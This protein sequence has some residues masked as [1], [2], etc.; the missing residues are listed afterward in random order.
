[1]SKFIKPNVLLVSIDA[2]GFDLA[3]NPE[4][5]G[6]RLPN[7][8][9]FLTEGAYSECG[10][11]PIF[12]SLTYCCHQSIITGTHP[13]THGTYA[14]KYFDPT[15]IYADAWYWYASSDVPTLWSMAKQ[16]GY[17]SV[18]VGFPTGVLADMD[19]NIP[20]I[21][22]DTTQLD[23]KLLSAV[24]LPQE[25]AREAEEQVGRIRCGLWD[26][27]DDATKLETCLWMLDEKIKPRLEQQPFFMTTYFAAYDD[28]AHHV[29]TFGRKALQYLEKT[30]EY[31][32]ILVE[33]AME[34]SGGNLVI[35]VIS[36]HGMTDNVCD[37]R[38]NTVFFQNDYLSIDEK[39]K[40]SDWKV[41]AQRGGGAANIQLKDKSDHG[42]REGVYQLLKDLKQKYP[43]LIDE[44][45]TGEQAKEQR[46]GYAEA[47]FVLTTKIGV[48]VRE[49]WDGDFLQKIPSQKAQ[50][51]YHEHLK[52]MRSMFL[53]QGPGIAKGR[54]LGN[55]SIVDIAPSL[56][57]IM[58]FEM[59]TS[60]G[61]NV[62]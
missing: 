37:I 20:E 23:S 34:L 31:L 40:I 45:M 3:L 15:G 51:G 52:D 18:N 44:V 29:G 62:L 5:Y 14:N 27:T 13:V 28:I 41:Y 55:F 2:V 19:L 1:M 49:E 50:H 25:L 24:S 21:W 60:E 57:G 30:D 42:L 61:K 4:Q 43:E 47:D 26:I 33:K 11:N 6:I 9:R 58:G 22:R 59:E 54:K 53:I 48:E 17:L 32:G 56:A 8:K 46:R 10:V 35:C 12:P 7:L 38:P 16:Q 36:D 39:G